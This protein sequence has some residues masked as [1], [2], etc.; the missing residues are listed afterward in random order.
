M[1]QVN[2]L[3]KKMVNLILIQYLKMEQKL[4]HGIKK[5]KHGIVNLAKLHQVINNVEQME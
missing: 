4:R 1:E 3:K 2:F 5:D